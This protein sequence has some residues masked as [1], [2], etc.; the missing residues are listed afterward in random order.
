[1][2]PLAKDFNPQTGYIL[3]S[4]AKPEIPE[5]IKQA[6]E[7][8]GLVEKPEFHIGVCVSQNAVELMKA[9]PATKEPEKT[10]EA[11]DQLLEETAFEYQLT[12][13]YV[14]LELFYDQH[15][16]GEFGY[17]GTPEH[18]RR[19]VAVK[20]SMP[21]MAVFYQKLAGIVNRTFSVPLP[22]LTLYAWADYAPMMTRG[23]GIASADDFKKYTKETL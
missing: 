6:A 13:E 11:I 17:V 22:H 1:M 9:I 5:R 18:H 21:D 16:L 2:H 19:A 20:L 14:F 3:L 10:K 23:I 12:D 15:K 4:V 8:R 7:A